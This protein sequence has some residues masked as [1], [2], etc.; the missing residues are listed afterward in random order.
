[1]RRWK[2]RPAEVYE[3]LGVFENPTLAAHS[4][5]LTD[6]EVDILARNNVGVAHCSFGNFLYPGPPKVH[7]MLRSGVNVGTGTD[8]A[9]AG[10]TLD[11]LSCTRITK[12]ACDSHFATPYVDKNLISDQQLIRM[13][14]I[15][16]ARALHLDGEIG[17]LEVGKRADVVIR[18]MRDL[19]CFPARDPFYILV[20][21]STEVHSVLLGGTLVL[22]NGWP[23][24]P[25]LAAAVADA[26]RRIGE[27]M[28]RYGLRR[29]A[30]G[31]RER[32]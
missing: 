25:S 32:R 28:D 3:D 23:A 7:L 16:G 9:V 14:T 17:S 8:G 15:G 20:N 21:C 31:R 10:G 2:K 1:M 4:V 18:R 19:D 26:R 24:N 12:I 29:A 22:E 27:I 11:L 6:R 30:W 13:A 5:L